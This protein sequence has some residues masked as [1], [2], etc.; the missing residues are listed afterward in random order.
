[1]A[2]MSELQVKWPENSPEAGEDR[3]RETFEREAIPH[4]D[5]LYIQ[6]LRM[7]LN[8]AD[9]DDLVQETYLKAF[10]FFESFDLGTNCKAWLFRIL[11]NSFINRFR[12]AKR[13]PATVDFADVEEYYQPAGGAVTSASDPSST[14]VGAFLG[15]EITDAVERL[16]IEFR[17]AVVLC[18]IE[19]LS[20][21]EIATL[22]DCP[23]GTI[24]SRLHRGRRQLR[25]ELTQYG[26]EQG[27]RVHG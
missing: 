15:D 11:K 13:N 3:R 6:A 14:V 7:T 16:P 8:P 26:I 2:D 1:M 17:T 12:R 21:E 9:A 10:R 25:K 23:V 27:Y 22:V 5:A 24:R 20:Y 4:L 19:G 18:D